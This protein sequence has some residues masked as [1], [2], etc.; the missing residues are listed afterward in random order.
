MT[1]PKQKR[2]T[3]W[4]IERVQRLTGEC[5][6]LADNMDRIEAYARYR[7]M[8]KEQNDTDRRRFEL[9]IFSYVWERNV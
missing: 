5:E 2:S 1:T 6:T 4:G 3:V 9:R 7:V 8:L